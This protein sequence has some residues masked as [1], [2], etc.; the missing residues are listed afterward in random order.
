[1][2]VTSGM[3]SKEKFEIVV[4]DRAPKWFVKKRTG[5]G[6]YITIAEGETRKEIIDQLKADSETYK[7]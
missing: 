2:V 5:S 4:D 1:M 3:V 6:V 7:K